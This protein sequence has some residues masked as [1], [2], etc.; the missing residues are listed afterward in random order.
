MSF[1]H[2]TSKLHLPLI[3]EAGILRVT[4]S[5][6]SPYKTHEGPDVVWL[7]D[8]K[9]G[10]PERGMHGLIGDNDKTAVRFEVDVPAIRWLDWEPVRNMEDWWLKTLIR[11]GG[12]DEAAEHWYVWPV[13]IL[14][15]R[16]IGIE[17]EGKPYGEL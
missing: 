15:K 1:F 7:L 13:G 2:F 4:E 14:R 9:A 8:E 17:V 3:L 10:Q 11:A 12:G 5:N 6:I 16:W